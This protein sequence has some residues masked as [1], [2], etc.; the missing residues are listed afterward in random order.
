MYNYIERLIEIIRSTLKEVLSGKKKVWLHL[1]NN[2]KDKTILNLKNI[3]NLLNSL[4]NLV[5]PVFSNDHEIYYDNKK[6]TLYNNFLRRI[7]A[8]AKK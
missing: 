4:W 3:Y 5:S 1:A 8:S 7:L 6:K 2:N